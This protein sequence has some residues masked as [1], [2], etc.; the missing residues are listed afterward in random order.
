MCVCRHPHLFI[1]ASSADQFDECVRYER[2]IS[3]ASCSHAFD[4]TR[5][6]CLLTVR[7]RYAQPFQQT[8]M[9]QGGAALID[10][11]IARMLHDKHRQSTARQTCEY[12][13]DSGNGTQLY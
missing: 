9:Q 10:Q 11:K 5:A 7:T 3:Q 2:W 4:R 6:H 8:L 1:R 13:Q 12:G